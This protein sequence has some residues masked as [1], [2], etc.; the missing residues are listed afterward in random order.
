MTRYRYRYRYRSWCNWGLLGSRSGSPTW[1]CRSAHHS[2]PVP[3]LTDGLL[4]VLDD[5]LG[6]VL[7]GL[8]LGRQEIRVEL[9]HMRQ[10]EVGTETILKYQY[11]IPGTWL[12]YVWIKDSD[13]NTGIRGTKIISDWFFKSIGPGSGFIQVPVQFHIVGGGPGSKA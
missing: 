8:Q 11:W 1:P 13:P 3:I 12:L 6:L 7:V 2:I 10:R 4:E 5:L 9:L